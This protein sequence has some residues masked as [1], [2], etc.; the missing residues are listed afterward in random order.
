M[1]L[2][3]NCRET[4]ALALAAQDRPLRLGERLRMGLHQ[5]MCAHCARFAHQLQCMDDALAQWRAEGPADGQEVPPPPP[6][7]DGS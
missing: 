6:A 7:R 1:A 5:R 3:P 4:T 2:L